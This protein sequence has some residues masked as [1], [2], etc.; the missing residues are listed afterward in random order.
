MKNELI[1]LNDNSF[2]CKIKMFFKKILFKTTEVE[3]IVP[4]N[5][6]TSEVIINN[7]KKQIDFCQG[8]DRQL[9]DLQKKYHTG[10]IKT[11]ELTPE[12]I[13]ELLKIYNKQNKELSA[14]NEWKK[15]KLLRYREKM[16]LAQ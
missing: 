6:S 15:Q 8:T 11:D 12:Q 7:N 1:K 3:E 10:E 9:L 2:F 5:K 16:R 4:A 13:R 14:S